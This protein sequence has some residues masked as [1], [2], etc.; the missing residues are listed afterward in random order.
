MAS[1]SVVIITRNEETQVRECLESCAFADEVVVV[2]SFST[3][4]YVWGLLFPLVWWLNQRLPFERRHWPR[5]LLRKRP[6][7]P[8]K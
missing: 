3:E 6:A 2:D 7:Q 8:L 1:L 5:W 4:W